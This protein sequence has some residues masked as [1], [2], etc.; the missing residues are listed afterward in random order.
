MVK[1]YM[2]PRPLHQLVC[3]RLHELLSSVRPP[4]LLVMADL[5]IDH[6]PRYQRDISVIS[7]LQINFH[8]M[9][10][11]PEAVKLA[12]EVVSP[13]SR[14]RDRIEKWRAY[15]R[16]GIPNYMLVELSDNGSPCVYYQKLVEGKYQLV[17]RARPGEILRIEEPI[18]IE[19]DPAGLVEIAP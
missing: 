4:E 16:L 9:A 1:W 17:D 8:L 12:V 10:I 14:Q 6:K 7:K 18:A 11:P 13:S 5:A 19:F 15:A 3:A 2:G